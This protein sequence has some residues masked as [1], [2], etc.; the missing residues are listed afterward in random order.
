MDLD[1]AL[2]RHERRRE[3]ARQRS[4][5]WVIDWR[6]ERRE[7]TAASKAAM[8]LGEVVYPVMRRIG[9]RVEQ[10][11]HRVLVT[12][13]THAGTPRVTFTLYP[14]AES[15]LPGTQSIF[16][17]SIGVEMDGDVPRVTSESTLAADGASFEDDGSVPLDEL[18]GELVAD[19]LAAFVAAA[20]EASREGASL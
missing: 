11:P 4:D 5:G 9:Q 20:L 1:Q 8:R 18:T 16:S 6:R 14:D 17:F 19:R 12:D 13:D 10:Y 3:Q 2:E 7:E 15:D